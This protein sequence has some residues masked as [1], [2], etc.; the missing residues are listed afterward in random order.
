MYTL[1]RPHTRRRVSRTLSNEMENS[2]ILYVR[3]PSIDNTRYTTHDSRLHPPGG[4]NKK[5]RQTLYIYIYT[6]S[7]SQLAELSLLSCHSFS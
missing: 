7:K 2:G 5:T 6:R 4:K 1:A 3:L